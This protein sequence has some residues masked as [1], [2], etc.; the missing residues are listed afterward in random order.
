M[1]FD[2]CGINKMFNVR[3]NLA[4]TEELQKANII[5]KTIRIEENRRR[6]SR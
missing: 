5:P 3:S 4:E 1:F 6:R 2:I